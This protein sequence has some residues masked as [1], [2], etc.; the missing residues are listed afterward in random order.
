MNKQINFRRATKS[1]IPAIIEL[2]EKL[3]DESKEFEPRLN[4]NKDTEIGYFLINP[5]ILVFS[6]FS[7]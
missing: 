6:K 2:G 1:D 3:Q 4:F 7:L 5:M